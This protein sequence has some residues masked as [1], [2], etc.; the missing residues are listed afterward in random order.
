MP[1]EKIPESLSNLRTENK[2]TSSLGIDKANSDLDSWAEVTPIPR[3]SVG[4]G[5]DGFYV[6]IAV[7]GMVVDNQ[8]GGGNV[9]KYNATN[10]DSY[11]N[12]FI[13]YRPC[14]VIWV[15][16]VCT[17][18]ASG[19]LD[20]IRC[21]GTQTKSTG[22]SVLSSTFALTPASTVVQKTGT[23]LNTTIKARQLKNGERLALLT[24]GSLSGLT[25]VV[26]TVYLKYLGAGLYRTK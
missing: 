8:E 11:D 17:G 9:N 15:S 16:L 26:V 22:T 13:A 20:I 25:S 5:K 18:T 3:T 10:A 19:A 6:T 1:E 7:N 4:T 12:F 14:E 2:I 23:G 24:S 21:T